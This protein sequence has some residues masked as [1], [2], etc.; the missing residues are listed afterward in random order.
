MKILIQYTQTG[1]YKDDAWETPALHL[2][3]QLHAV[4]PSY[5]AQ[6]IQRN[7]ASLYTDENKN[8]V[9]SA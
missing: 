2:K 3:G 5:A 8:V 1:M 6:L 7:Q 9:I 4:S